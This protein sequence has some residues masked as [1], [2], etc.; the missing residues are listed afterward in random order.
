M[1]KRELIKWAEHEK[2]IAVEKAKENAK[3]RITE[4]REFYYEQ[5]GVNDFVD[6]VVPHFEAA[7]KEY[8]KFYSKID[9]TVGVSISKYNGPRGYYGIQALT[10]KSVI[11]DA[12]Q[13]AIRF[14]T[15]HEMISKMNK[16]KDDQRE[17]TNTYDT[18]VETL[19]NLPSAKEGLEYLA[20]LGFNVAT[21]RPLEEKKQLPAT[22]DVNVDVR[23][24][25]LNKK[26][27]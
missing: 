16:V 11:K 12:L 23:Y 27:N 7:F 10:E 8:E 24:L 14:S 25:L 5:I 15:H 17:V 3:N 20:K 4:I 2:A 19:K 13:E 6:S 21:I 26:A 18:V 22:T 1:N 9:D